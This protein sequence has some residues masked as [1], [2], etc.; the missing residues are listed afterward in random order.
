VWHYCSK[1][2]LRGE[3]RAPNNNKSSMTR[4]RSEKRK[5]EMKWGK[6]PTI[7]NTTLQMALISEYLKIKSVLI[8]LLS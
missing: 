1:R 6:T 7:T 8:I 2:T 4:R 3:A 5:K